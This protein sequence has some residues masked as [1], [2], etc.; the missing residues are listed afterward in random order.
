MVTPTLGPLWGSGNHDT[1]CWWSRHSPGTSGTGRTPS[2][3]A[4][5]GQCCSAEEIQD[6]VENSRNYQ[7]IHCYR[8]KQ[9]LG[10][11][12]MK[13][14][15][16]WIIWNMLDKENWVDISITTPD[17]NNHTRWIM[18]HLYQVKYHN[19]ITTQLNLHW[20]YLRTRAALFHQLK[21]SP[22]QQHKTAI[23]IMELILQPTKMC[24]WAF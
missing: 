16:K 21:I 3:H 2:L 14:Y 5:P 11:N 9:N 8:L 22:V 7:V 20:L 13:T 18:C 19:I 24:N 4:A 1:L 15:M 12:Y 10:L 6:H 23:H 17:F